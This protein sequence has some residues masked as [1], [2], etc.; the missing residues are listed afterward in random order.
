MEKIDGT[1]IDPFSKETYD[2]TYN[3]LNEGIYATRLRVA[4]DIASVEKDKDYWTEKFIYLQEDF[5]FVP[6]G[7]IVSNAGTGLKGTTYINC[8][9]DGFTGEDQDSMEGILS[10]LRRQALI[11]KSEGGYGF[12]A[13]V[14]RPRGSF[15]NGIGND[16]PGA[17]KMLDM[18]DTQSAVITEGSGKAKDHD[19]GKIKIRKGAQM[20]TESVT[21]PDIEE[22][23]TAKQTPGRL[24][25]FNMSVLITDEFMD[26]VKKHKK[27]DLIFP[28][29]DWNIDVYKK[30]WDGNI[31]KWKEKGYPVKVYKT[32]EDANELWDLITISTYNK[33]EP[34]ILF[35]DRMNQLNN[36]WYCEYLSATNPCG[37]Q[38]LPIGGVCLLG[39]INLTQ[40]IN[41]NR[42][43]FDYDKLK[44]LIPIAVRFMDNVNDITNVP[45]EEQK[46]NLKEKRRIGLGIMG[47]G[48]ALMIMKQRYGSKK[49]LK[50]TDKLMKF[51]M[52][53]TYRASIMLAKE[54]GSFP[55]YDKEKYMTGNFIKNLDQDVLD[56][57]KL[58]GIRNSHLLSIQPN[59][60]SS[61][62]A[63]VVS[64]GQEPVFMPE[65]IRTVSVPICPDFLDVPKNVDFAGKKFISKDAWEWINEGDES[66]L[67]V[68]KNGDT[69]KFDKSRGLL[70]EVQCKDY[71]VRILEEYGEW[72]SKA[73]WAATIT[74]L[75]I[76]EHVNTMLVLSKYID[77]AMSKT[78]NLPNDYPYEDFKNLYM[79][80]YDSKTV[81]GCTTYR[82]GT[83]TE[84]LASI[85]KDDKKSN[86]IEKNNAP[87][88][89]VELAHDIH[90]VSVK[91]EKWIVLVGL[92]EGD[93][94]EV[95]AFKPKM[96]H[97]PTTVKTGTLKK[98]KR[99]IY[100]LTC[101]NGFIIENISE[102]FETDE[103]ESLTRMISTA[104]RHGTDIQFI[105]EQLNKSNGDITSF[106]KAIGRS[107]K[108]YIKDG[109]KV[110]EVCDNCGGVDTLVYQEGCLI[111]RN[112][113]SSVCS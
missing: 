25:K 49:A 39:S 41:Q 79:K 103:Q 66:L 2:N 8:F 52:N 51:I 61:I 45:L 78:V 56:L 5:K 102:N 3:Y 69:F 83:M 101:D 23:I 108:K 1:F 99:G 95:F 80:L 98:V 88:R 20:V 92:L 96:I 10:A 73:D 6:G 85:K 34:G 11:L 29:Y 91:G 38:I 35:L 72:D 74:D 81:K 14:M 43:D 104:L 40:F 75:S 37:E 90:H 64:G 86:K 30:E 111:C 84:V 93:P 32:F 97:I 4:K 28:D 105:Y 57:M 106:N 55:K 33:N 24:T 63:N 19:K 42:T 62:F 54:K 31:K 60:N 50:M 27:W 77:S 113:G 26:A 12:C 18:W 59:G 47:Y 15:I 109:S 89:P 13:D 65:Y 22:F 71:A 110:K 36:L 94:F 17:V 48:S 82:I 7:R 70:K 68:S 67:K 107:L 21:A 100:N 112:C 46:A 44:E 76:D 16:S 87:K 53:E 9:V 58:Y